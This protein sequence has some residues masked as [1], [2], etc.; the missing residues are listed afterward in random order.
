MTFARRLTLLALAAGLMSTG[1]AGASAHGVRHV[2]GGLANPRGMTVGPDGAL[3][4]AEA[5]SGGSGPCIPGPEGGPVCLGATGAIA[6][7]DP[8]SGRVRR[9]VSGLPSL[10]A[11]PGSPGAGTNAAGPQDVSF[12]PFGAAWFTVGLGGDT[13]ARDALGPGGQGLGRLYVRA[14]FGRVHSV[15]DLAAYETQN[16][17]DGVTPP[18]SNPYSVDAR[19]PWRVLVT[20]AGGN[21]LLRVRP[22]GRVSTVTVFPG[23]VA[24]APPFVGVPF[25]AVPTGVVRRRGGVAY[26]GQLTGFPF[27]VGLANVYA[28]QR[29]GTTTVKV[30]GL[31]TVV[32]V[33]LGRHGRLYVLQI[34][35]AGLA[36]PPSPGKLLRI[37]PDGTQTELAAGQLTEPT[38]LAVSRRG[39]VYVANNGGSPTD[40]EIVKITGA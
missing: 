27:P 12:G 8:W 29:D 7:V 21:D 23:G 35:T 30:G 4:V 1:V 19:N 6:R 34:S 13:V 24:N 17:P 33:A 31:T 2:A 38:G 28:V 20:D 3:W 32:D 40:G 36:G 25:Q 39:D 26:V 5:G 37:D 22:W 9:V 16:N 15:A 10:A 18:D 11:A 14:P